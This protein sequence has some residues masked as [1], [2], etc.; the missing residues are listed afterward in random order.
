M[1]DSAS[2]E[3]EHTSLD[4]VCGMTVKLP[5]THHHEHDGETYNFCCAGCR[6]KFSAD[7]GYYLRGEHRKTPAAVEGASSYT[8]PMDP[9]IVQ[10]EPG[11]CPICGMALEPM[12]VSLDD[13]ENPELVDM[14]RRF[15]VS[16][17]LSL[18]VLI[19]AMGEM[20]GL[21]FDGLTW[22][23]CCIRLQHRCDSCASEVSRFVSG[24]PR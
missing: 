9:E 12:M 15:R 13:Q 19:L 16:A 1:S 18:P 22:H 11:T 6:T 10:D 17:A 20:V 23:R 2:T 8:C 3:A 24:L 7:P 21:S 14:T 5:S 4:P